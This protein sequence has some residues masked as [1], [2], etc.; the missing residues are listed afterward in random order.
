MVRKIMKSDSEA[1]DNI[2]ELALKRDQASAND[3]TPLTL[4]T[5]V[6]G[7]QT[8]KLPTK[9]VKTTPRYPSPPHPQTMKS[10]EIVQE[11]ESKQPPEQ[12][13]TKAQNENITIKREEQV[14]I[15]PQTIPNNPSYPFNCQ[16]WTPC[17]THSGISFVACR[18]CKERISKSSNQIQFRSN[19]DACVSFD[20]CRDCIKPVLDNS[21]RC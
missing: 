18:N 5:T 10:V 16:V 11:E 15:Q 8:D 1:V 2:G 14:V 20:L 21:L 3:T 4:E 12:A 6:I 7:Y 9:S 17:P 19:G 13:E